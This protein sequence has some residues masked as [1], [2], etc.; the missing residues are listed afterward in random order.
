MFCPVP[1]LWQG[2]TRGVCCLGAGCIADG[3]AL[4]ESLGQK[5]LGGR[6]LPCPL[7]QV[8]YCKDNKLHRSGVPTPLGLLFLFCNESCISFFSFL[9]AQVCPLLRRAWPSSAPHV[10]R[11]D[12]PLI[13]FRN[14]NKALG[15]YSLLANPNP[16]KVTATTP[17][18]LTMSTWQAKH[19]GV[20]L[21]S[22]MA[23]T[24]VTEYRQPLHL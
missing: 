21:L 4:M 12:Y 3:L 11:I 9:A 14:L 8:A 10:P 13:K 17:Y 6:P 23:F 19:L 5:E 15:I 2:A 1:G 7:Y 20:G 22:S 18:C 24:I 16:L